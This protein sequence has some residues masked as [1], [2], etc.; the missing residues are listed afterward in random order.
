VLWFDS[1]RAVLGALGHTSVSRAFD[2]LGDDAWRA[3]ERQVILD[4]AEPLARGVEVWSLGGGALASA[5]VRG[6]LLDACVVWL[7][8]PADVLWERVAG[9]DRPLARDWEKF[10]ALHESRTELYESIAT[11]RVDAT[12]RVEDMGLGRLLADHLPPNWF[13][14]G[15][16]VG[17]GLLDRFVDLAALCAGPIAMVSD[18]AVDSIATSV[19][20]QLDAAGIQ[21]VSD[22]RIP[23]GEWNKQ[24]TTVEA[25]LNEWAGSGLHRRGTVVAIG[26][27][28]LLDT[29]GFAASIFQ[30]G[31][32][33]VS[34]PTTVTSQVDAGIGGKT[35]VN[36]GVGTNVLGTVH[37]PRATLID[38]SFGDML[39]AD[40]IRDGFV[41][42]AKTGL[43]AGEW[44]LERA[45]DVAQGASGERHDAWR[46]V[47]EGCGGF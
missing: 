34:V 45:R 42:A 38:T 37:M 18:E 41:E 4:R 13:G 30:R 17:D 6:A 35:G 7:D 33:W 43:L 23:M 3:A 36:L 12:T 47:N 10:R 8:A 24:L 27:G 5:D 14:S 26:G 40:V 11:V 21:V 22:E 39:P 29:T 15:L 16:A 46:A 1:D 44:L 31:V 28:T 9:S 2:E 19:R 25:L 20:A 32:D